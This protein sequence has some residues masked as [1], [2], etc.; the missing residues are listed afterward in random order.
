MK[1]KKIAYVSND[2]ECDICHGNLKAGTM[3]YDGRTTFGPWAWMCVKC[4]HVHGSG[5]GLGLGQEYDS[6]TNEKIRG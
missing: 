4:F 3:F 1:T 6:T 5:V 2:Q